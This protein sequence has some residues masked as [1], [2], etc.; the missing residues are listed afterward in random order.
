MNHIHQMQSK[1]RSACKHVYIILYYY[2]A[3]FLFVSPVSVYRTLCTI[4]TYMSMEKCIPN[5]KNMYNRGSPELIKS[6]FPK[7]S[8]DHADLKAGNN[9]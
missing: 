8:A 7:A 1:A 4:V 6:S 5:S 9:H 2:I 3:D